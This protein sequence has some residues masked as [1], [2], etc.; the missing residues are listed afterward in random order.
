MQKCGATTQA[1][2]TFVWIWSNTKDTS[3]SGDLS[4]FATCQCQKLS[5]NEQH[6]STITAIFFKFA[7]VW[8]GTPACCQFWL[9]IKL[10]QKTCL[11][12]KNIL[13]LLTNFS[14][15]GSQPPPTIIQPSSWDASWIPGHA[16]SCLHQH[17]PPN[18]TQN[19]ASG[20]VII[21]SNRSVAA[22]FWGQSSRAL[23]TK[24]ALVLWS[25]FNI[26]QHPNLPIIGYAWSVLIRDSRA[27]DSSRFSACWTS[28]C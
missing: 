20:S 12:R 18:K 11:I 15:F 13:L 9:T 24:A 8:A 19:M 10:Q 7:N 21:K 23:S 16:P 4:S 3:V 22:T 17:Q 28:C 6:G 25:H 1:E 26:L 5:S 27:H 14:L 2:A